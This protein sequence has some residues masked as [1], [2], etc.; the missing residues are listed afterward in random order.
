RL[1]APGNYPVCG[2]AGSRGRG[3]LTNLDGWRGLKRVEVE[4]AIAGDIV[5]VAG[6]ED[7]H[8][9]EAVADRERPEPLPPIRIDQPTIAMV[10]AV[11][12]SPWGGRS[13]SYVTSRN[14][15][16][17]L[18]QE[19]RRNVS[20]RVEE[21]TTT[22]AFRVLGRGELQLAILIETMRREGYELQASKPA[23][24]VRERDGVVEEPM[25]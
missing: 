12:T 23:P 15:R 9:G 8:I 2:L 6:I 22:D 10:F 7:I 14:L 13:G 5:A 20:L 3:K 11:N 4:R 18:L 19:A 25:E 21:T 24:V 1:V 17:R 16:E